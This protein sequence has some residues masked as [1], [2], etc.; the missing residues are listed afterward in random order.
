ME[1]TSEQVGDLVEY[2]TLDD[3]RIARI[4]LNR[5]ETHN[6]QNRTLLVQ[7]DE[8]FGRAEADDAVRVV[9]LAARGKNFSAGHDL[10]SEAAVAERRAGPAQHPTFRSHGGTREPA[11]EKTYLQEWHYYFANTCR[12]RELRKITI[13]QVQGNTISAGLMLIWACDLIVAADNARFSD[14]VGVRLGMPGVE[15]YAHPWEFGPR[16]AKELLLTGDSLD[17]DEAYRLGMVSKV[18]GVDELAEKTLEFARRIAQLP[19]M[20]ALLIKDSVN[21]AADA[22]GFS[23]ALRHG[24]HIHQLG[25]AHWSAHNDNKFPIALPPEVPDWRTATATDLARRDRP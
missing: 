9:I 12:W 10:G 18:F 3:G 17:A 24:F 5:P 4:W 7:L 20:A 11:V 1:T 8:A 25:H 13:A 21:A 6:A 15:Y 2:E 16:K 14:V 19:T 23:E 22:M